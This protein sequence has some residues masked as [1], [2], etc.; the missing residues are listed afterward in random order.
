MGSFWYHRH[1]ICVN[2]GLTLSTARLVLNYYL[3]NK[4]FISDT[5]SRIVDKN[6]TGITVEE[7]VAEFWCKDM[8]KQL[9]IVDQLAILAHL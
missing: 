6:F 1:T 8:L 3:V 2:Q 9:L 7:A 5:H 4:I